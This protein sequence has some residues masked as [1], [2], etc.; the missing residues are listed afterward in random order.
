MAWPVLT[1][2][3][4][5]L[6]GDGDAIAGVTRK[7]RARPGYRVEPVT[8]AGGARAHDFELPVVGAK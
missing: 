4:V 8:V 3:R 2:A 7:L 5:L 6:V 1:P